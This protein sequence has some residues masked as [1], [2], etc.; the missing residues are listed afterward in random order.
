[1]KKAVIP[2]V[3][4]ILI[5][6]G[7]AWGQDATYFFNLGLGSSA[8]NKKIHYFTKALELNPQLAVAYDRRGRLYYF[9]EDYDKMMYDF[10]K[11][12]DLRP[13]DPQGYHMLGLAHL[14]RGNVDVAIAK[15]SR[16]LELEP[17]LASAYGYRAEAYHL[18]G[19]PEKA[20]RDS[21]R[22]IESGGTQSTVGRA[23]TVRSKAYKQLGQEA[24]AAADFDKAYDLDPE[25]Y[26]YKYFNITNHLA[27]FTN[28]S[29]YIDPGDMRRLGLMG[30]IAVLA[31]LIFKLVLPTPRK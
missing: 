26:A 3:V 24:L 14:R 17:K 28:D 10:Y 13:L 25:N 19:F 5:S 30:I 22:A 27:S 29:S 18:K 21:T 23:Y 16:A 15:F 31:V 11:F 12:T 4:Y 9:K 7:P 1:M 6:V 2:F 8:V 20:V